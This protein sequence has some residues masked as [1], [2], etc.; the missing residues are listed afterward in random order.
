MTVHSILDH[1]VGGFLCRL[2]AFGRTSF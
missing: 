1:R 2:V